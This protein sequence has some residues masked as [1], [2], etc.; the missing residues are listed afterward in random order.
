M[1]QSRILVVDD[2]PIILRVLKEMLEDAGYE[3]VAARNGDE[4]LQKLYAEAGSFHAVVLDRV[5]PSKDGMEVLAAIRADSRF[6][7]LPV[8]MQTAAA[9][10]EEIQQGLAA[11]VFC[12]ITKPFDE[13][14]LI[15][16]VRAAVAAGARRS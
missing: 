4:A 15:D 13:A 6:G 16:T 2:E 10:D 14:T 5:M 8:I 12:Y 7:D 9:K 1:S 3:A 11:G